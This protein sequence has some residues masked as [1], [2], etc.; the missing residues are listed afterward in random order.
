[1]VNPTKAGSPRKAAHSSTRRTRDRP[2]SQWLVIQP[3]ELLHATRHRPRW[4]VALLAAALGV[5][6]LAFVPE[7]GPIGVALHDKLNHLLAFGTLALLAALSLPAAARRA[8]LASGVLLYG[9][10]IEIVQSQ[11]PG[12]SAE[13]ADLAA[14]AAGTVLG[15]LLAAALRR[16]WPAP[17]K[18]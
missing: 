17:S 9:G 15:L 3:S 5:A 14:D 13:W 6:W 2:A 7:P 16:A 4:R 11:L 1:M 10:F 18:R 8:P 12:R